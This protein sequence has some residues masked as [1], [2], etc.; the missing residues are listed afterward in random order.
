MRRIARERRRSRHTVR[1]ALED[2]APP[3]YRR[4]VPK[5]RPV[6]GPYTPLIDRLLSQVSRARRNFP[7][8]RHLNFP[9]RA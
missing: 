1:R 3:A 9:V 5:P 4:K 7:G 2:P 8:S 6:L